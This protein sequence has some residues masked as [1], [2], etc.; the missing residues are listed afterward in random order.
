L[1]GDQMA[2]KPMKVKLVT[3]GVRMKPAERRVLERLAAMEDKT[4]SR[5]AREAMQRGIL[6][7]VVKALEQARR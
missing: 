5:V 1:E 3:V 4:L 6:P 7:A 2:Q